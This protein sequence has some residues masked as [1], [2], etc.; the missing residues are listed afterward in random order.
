MAM[1]RTGRIIFA[2]VIAACSARGAAPQATP[3]ESV[4]VPEG[5]KVELLRSAENKEGTWIAMTVD[6]KGRLIIS[7]QEG[8][9]PL[10]RMTVKPKGGVE[11]IERIELPIRT[12]MGMLHAFGSLYVSGNGPDGTGIYRLTDKDGDDQYDTLKLLKKFPGGAGEHGAH[13]IVLGPD[14]MLYVINGNS[15]P[16]PE[17]IDPE[18]PFQNYREDDLLPRVKDP[19][20]TFFDKLK[21]PYGYLLR[22][23]AEGTKWELLSAGMRNVYDIDF[24]SD[25]ELFAYDSDMEW[26]WGASWY[27]PT[28]VLHMVSGAEF[29]FREGSS[30][31]PEYYAD[32]TPAVVDIGIGSP[33]GVKYGAK[34]A[35]PPQYRDSMFIAD[36]SYGRILAVRL[37]EKG[38]S[39][40]GRFEPFVQGKPLNVADLEIGADGAMYFITGGRAVQSGLYRVSYT[41]KIPEAPGQEK[42]AEALAAR[43]LR[44]QLEAFH[45]KRDPKAIETA[46]QHLGSKDRFIRFAARV[47]IESQPVDEWQQRALDEDDPDRLLGA[48][49]ALGRVGGTSV[50]E[51][52]FAAL[53]KLTDVTLDERQSLD[54][55]RIMQISLARQ[56]R[57]GEELER[58]IV[59]RLNSKYPSRSMAVNHELC[60]ILIFLN[61]P[62]VVEKTLKLMETAQFQEDQTRFALYLRLARS[63][64]KPE[65]RR[66]YFT[67]FKATRQGSMSDEMYPKGSGY[68]AWTNQ[69]AALQ[70]HPAH[71]VQWFKDVGWSYGDGASFHKFMERIRDE[72]VQTL[73]PDERLSL[74]PL[75]RPDPVVIKTVPKR[76]H[77]FVQEWKMT[78]FDPAGIQQLRGRSFENGQE[79]F[80][81]AQCLACHK[82]GNEGGSVGPDLTTVASRFGPR[83]V[84]ESSIEPSKVVSEQFQSMRFELKDGDDVSGLIVDETPEKYSVLINP[85]ES[86]K[87][88][89]P[90]ANIT[91]RM[92][93]K[94]SP[95]PEGLLNILTKEEILDL[96]AYIQSGGKSWDPVFKK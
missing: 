35:F 78:N 93:S 20:A 25:G 59:D 23:D 87:M 61:A 67:W 63:G 17:G 2:F 29:G 75:L 49:L 54:A 37:Q 55:L 95:M 83:D 57:P 26:E 86:V 32:S 66:R 84:L 16:L 13:A 41:G 19:L 40:T 1:H 89:I 76:E 69:A 28:R 43:K 74:A 18:S 48:L 88:D 7:P 58:D 53:D 52:L 30:K 34:A 31:W 47:A 65:E 21:A 4:K 90:K 68:F 73:T 46:W 8:H 70:R 80:A 3:A 96:L 9:V 85:L 27:R 38:A 91:S 50:Q 81:A 14:K 77:K 92:P 33:T 10:L 11:K 44:K 94:L 64:W 22:T 5:F 60:Q 24:N 62:G 79:A 51:E 15:T 82:F 39:Y 45:G 72:A 71:V 6:P 36:W 56:G 12:S 42:S